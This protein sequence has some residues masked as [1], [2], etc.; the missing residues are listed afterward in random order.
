MRGSLVAQRACALGVAVLTVLTGFVFAAPPASATGET[1]WI[2]DTAVLETGPGQTFLIRSYVFLSD[3]RP[4][5]TKVYFTTSDDTAVA[6]SDYIARTGYVSIA[7]GKT[8]AVFSIKGLGDA[9]PEPSPER[10]FV[11]LTGASPGVTID[12]DQFFGH[13]MII[14]EDPTNAATV[15]IGD[16]ALYE[17]NSG[18]QTASVAISLSRPVLT[19]TSITYETVSGTAT[20]P[21][22]YKSK[23]VTTKILAGRTSINATAIVY[24]NTAPESTRR[25]YFEIVAAGVPIARLD[26]TVKII[27]DDGASPGVSVG[28]STV[29]EGDHGKKTMAFTV[30]LNAPSNSDVI[31]HYCSPSGTAWA[32]IDYKGKCTGTVKVLANKTTAKISLTVYGETLDEVVESFNLILTDTNGS[33]IPIVDGT[34]VGVIVDDDGTDTPCLD[35]T[36]PGAGDLLYDGQLGVLGNAAGYGGSTDGTCSTGSY[37]DFTLLAAPDLAAAAAACQALGVVVFAD[38]P[39]DLGYPVPTDWWFCV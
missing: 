8:E 10:F 31:I 22:D 11:Y 9:I 7:A 39:S 13:P 20:A 37:A 15:S 12:P 26:G 35:S 25:F 21:A 14:D 23:T 17:G 38:K 24:G 2:Q 1:V 4:T 33:G 30:T 32:Q 19:D 36:T 27:D 3:P 28:D 5:T 29:V 34:G 18:T 6:G 16:T